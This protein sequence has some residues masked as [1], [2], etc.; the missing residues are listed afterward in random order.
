MTDDPLTNR[1]TRPGG[2]GIPHAS[3]RVLVV[4]D[5]DD[6]LG[7][8]CALL[9][10]LGH[11]ARGAQ[12]G[13]AGLAIAKAW[14][15]DIVLLDVY[16]PLRT[17]FE[18]AR[19]FRAAFPPGTMRLIM[20]SGADLDEDALLD[21]GRAGFDQCIDKMLLPAELNRLILA[22]SDLPPGN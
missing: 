19:E 8:L 20:M 17:G 1:A 2:A 6:F 5:N 9:R 15:P 22:S 21:A 10:T 3:R 7:T 16:L 11:E 13:A 12:D 4:D 14:R 18:L